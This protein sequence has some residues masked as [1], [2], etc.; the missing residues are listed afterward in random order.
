MK[1]LNRNYLE[2]VMENNVVG[3]EEGS[4]KV[5]FRVGWGWGLIFF[6]LGVL[7]F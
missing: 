1:W 6:V 4:G 3:F 5:F 7:S 2:I